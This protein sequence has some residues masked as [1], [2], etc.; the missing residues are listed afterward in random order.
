MRRVIVKQLKWC[1]N[2]WVE[3]GELSAVY[4]GTFQHEE[5]PVIVVEYSS[6]VV[7]AVGLHRVRFLEPPSNDARENF[8]LQFIL[9]A[10]RSSRNLDW[11]YSRTRS[12][13]IDTAS[14]L[15]RLTVEGVK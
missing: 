14:E 4:H 15:Y 7:E 6:G 13:L 9:E 8:I 1:N 11:E 2:L 12:V 5:G 3:E 10:R